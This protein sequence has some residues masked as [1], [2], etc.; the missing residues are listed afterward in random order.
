MPVHTFFENCGIPLYFHSCMRLCS[1]TA[2]HFL[3]LLSMYAKVLETLVTITLYY[4]CMCT[5]PASIV[6]WIIIWKLSPPENDIILFSLLTT[7]ACCSYMPVITKSVH[8][9]PESTNGLH[10]LMHQFYFDTYQSLL[11]VSLD[12]LLNVE[13]HIDSCMHHVSS[14]VSTHQ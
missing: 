3:F 4:V 5:F 8:W 9:S 11:I 1:T 12:H 6:C 13:V 14:I 7:L 10:W 2:L